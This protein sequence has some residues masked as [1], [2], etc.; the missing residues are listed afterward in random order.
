MN[1]KQFDWLDDR[2]K[3]AADQHEPPFDEASWQKLESRLDNS[4]PKRRVGWWWFTDA[5]ILG[6]LVVI[7]FNLVSPG[8]MNPS[9]NSGKGEAVVAETKAKTNPSDPE[10]ASPA[11][12]TARETRGGSSARP[13][14]AAR[15]A[16][17]PDC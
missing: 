5:L 7:A 9:S 17:S 14:P 16:N 10:S 13:S 2:F 3:E 1:E 12:E 4:K 11:P 8:T 6:L 15:S